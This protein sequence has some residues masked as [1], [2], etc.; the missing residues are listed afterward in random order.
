MITIYI[1]AY[2]PTYQWL[3][4][5]PFYPRAYRQRDIYTPAAS[6]DGMVVARVFGLRI[7]DTIFYSLI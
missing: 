4:S 2:F 7:L 1:N 5:Q 6:A 3:P